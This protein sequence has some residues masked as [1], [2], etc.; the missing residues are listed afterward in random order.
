MRPFYGQGQKLF[1]LQYRFFKFARDVMVA[2]TT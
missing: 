2:I 1:L